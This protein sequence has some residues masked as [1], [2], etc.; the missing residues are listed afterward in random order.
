MMGVHP[1]LSMEEAQRKEAELKREAL[2]R[3]VA[4]RE[5][6]IAQQ[7]MEDRWLMKRHRD[8]ANQAVDEERH[9]VVASWAERRARVEEEIAYN[10]EA[11]RFQSELWQRGVT[12]PADAEEDISATALADTDITGSDLAQVD[13]GRQS[14]RCAVTGLAG[15][16][17]ASQ[18]QI[19]PTHDVSFVNADEVLAH[20][21]GDT[22]VR[23]ALESSQLS[24][25]MGESQNPQFDR[26]AN[27]RRINKHLLKAS[28]AEDYDIDDGD[29]DPAPVSIFNTEVGAQHISLSAYTADCNRPA[30]SVVR[31]SDDSD[32]VAAVCDQWS[33]RQQTDGASG[34]NFHEI[35]FQQQ[36]EAEA[37]KR[38]L[39]R[40]NCPFNA[41][42]VDSALVMPSHYIK[43]DAC[44]FKMEPNLTTDNLPSWLQD[45]NRMGGKKKTKRPTARKSKARARKAR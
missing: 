39:A 23:F 32:V 4:E 31:S 15:A 3:E 41:A 26:V 25:K 33:S 27:L 9:A 19:A 16:P 42:V 1:T 29:G 7:N 38:M 13:A 8:I 2:E 17:F 44:T 11:M 36:Q 28:E 34:P 14:V 21:K 43:P 37:V 10:A 30:A 5:A 22:Q 35:R 18:Q 12:L 45:R 40:R 20:A 6:A 24:P